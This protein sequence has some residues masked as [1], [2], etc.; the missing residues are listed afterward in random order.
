MDVIKLVKDILTDALTVP[1]MTEIPQDRPTRL[2]VIGLEGDMSTEFLLIPRITL[3]CWGSSD[4]DAHG[5]ALSAVYALQDAAQD[6]PYL[7]DVA[8]ETM[9]REEWSRNGQPRYMASLT[10]TINTD[11]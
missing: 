6:H 10:L 3:I 5:I 11:E 4:K 9:S 1:V 7:S 8:L 2:V